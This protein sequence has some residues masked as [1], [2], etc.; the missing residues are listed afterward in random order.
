[1]DVSRTHDDHAF[2]ISAFGDSPFLASCLASLTRQ[3]VAS[4]LVVT[5]ATPSQFIAREAE[6]FGAPMIV[7]EHGRNIAEDW[8]FALEAI[9]ARYVTIAHQDDVYFDRFVEDS[10]AALAA[11]PDAVLSFTGCREIDDEG[12]PR[13]SRTDL[14]KQLL[15]RAILGR[16]ER[17]SGAHLRTFLSF[18]NP[19]ACS[20]VTFDK[21]RLEGF[22]FSPRYRSNLDWDAWL[23]LISQGGV[24]ARA[25]AILVGR[26]RNPL[27]A[28]S[29]LIREG[30]RQ[31]ED[32][33]LFR[34]L[35]PK[36]LAELIA[37]GYRTGY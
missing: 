18:G 29:R 30:V 1:M 37:Q 33:A 10:L 28:T 16:A 22:A 8:N 25:P 27:T 21:T 34:R 14:V 23:R 3:S 12:R 15:D 20:S 24:F 2:A 35:W 7:N 5:T 4:R 19:L 13:F 26:R 11:A 36:P 6:R 17:V 31:S 9:D 32:L